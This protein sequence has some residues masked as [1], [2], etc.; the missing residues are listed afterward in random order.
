MKHKINTRSMANPNRGEAIGAFFGI[1]GAHSKYIIIVKVKII[2]LVKWLV[3][4][5]LDYVRC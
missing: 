1:F 4:F 2:V 3:Y 5:S